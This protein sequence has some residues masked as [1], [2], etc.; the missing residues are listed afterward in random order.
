[1]T[2][3]EA[4]NRL[5]LLNNHYIDGFE[6]ELT[7]AIMTL[8]KQIPKKIELFNGQVFCPNCKKL[9]GNYNDLKEFISWHCK[10]CGQALDWSE[11]E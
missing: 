5:E 4:I 7:Q 6:E 2:V 1:M 3:Q 9:F 10:Y 11:E 8:E